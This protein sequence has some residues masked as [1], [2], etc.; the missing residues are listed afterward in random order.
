MIRDTIAAIL[1]GGKGERLYLVNQ[2]GRENYDG[3]DFTI[4]DEIIVIH[5]DATLPDD[6][7]I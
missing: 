2:H 5:K 7:V 3:P 4:R 6:I 1:G